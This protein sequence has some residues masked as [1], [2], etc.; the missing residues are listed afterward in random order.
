MCHSIAAV[1]QQRVSVN[2][3]ATF[4]EPYAY[5]PWRSGKGLLRLLSFFPSLNRFHPATAKGESEEAGEKAPGAGGTPRLGGET[6]HCKGAELQKG[7][8]GKTAFVSF[9][10][11]G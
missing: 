11:K 9:Y 1:T 3:P 5:R 2:S 7:G 10:F 4:S 6:D 8:G